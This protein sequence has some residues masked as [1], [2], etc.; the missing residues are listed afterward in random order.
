MS[1]TLMLNGTNYTVTGN[2]MLGGGGGGEVVKPTFTETQLIDNSSKATSFTF[3]TDYHNSDFVR[4]EY[5][6]TSTDAVASIIVTPNT[7]DAIFQYVTYLTINE[8][9]NTNYVSYT[10]STLTWSRSSASNLVI[11]AVYGMAC[12]MTV[13]EVELYQATAASSS[14][15]SV[16]APDKLNK[17]DWIM[18]VG[19]SADTTE[20]IP[21][22]P[23][24]SSIYAGNVGILQL[25]DNYSLFNIDTEYTLSSNKYF[26]VCGIKFSDGSASDVITPVLDNGVISTDSAYATATFNDVSDYSY[27]LIRIR[28]TVSSVDYRAELLVKVSDIGS[29]ISLYPTVHR[30]ITVSLT[31]TSIGAT[32]YSGSYYYIYA[33]IV[34][35]ADNPF[36]VLE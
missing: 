10:E 2:L 24:M 34:A 4:I 13:T 23:I 5:T 16:T 22:I 36:D 21:N 14:S 33:D 19:N 11:T 30:Q 9:N 20:I 8:F 12:N 28:D 1:G 7:L 18:V 6:N 25:Y 17:Y 3:S 29:G 15:V 35:L 26:R 31:T 27:L 32:N